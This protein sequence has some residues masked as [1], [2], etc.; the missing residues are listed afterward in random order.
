[1]ANITAER[2]ISRYGAK[3][4]VLPEVINLPMSASLKIWKG[5][6]V[7][8]SLASATKGQA[9]K[10]GASLVQQV[11]GVALQTVDNSSG[12]AGALSINVEAGCFWFGN[13]GGGDAIDLQHIGMPA[14]VVDDQTVALT[15]NGGARL[16]GGTIINLD[17]SLGVLVAVGVGVAQAQ[18]SQG[19]IALALD[20]TSAANATLLTFTPQ[21]NGRIKK[22]SM[23]VN[24]AA[25][26]AGAT[27]TITPN[28]AASPLTGG[29]LTP[30]LGSATLGA[31]LAATAITGAN[32]FTAGQAIT[33]VGSSFTAFTAGNG[34]IY[35]HLG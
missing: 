1:M 4:A 7:A 15:D 23:S 28:I 20:L 26:G 11:V 33:L 27:V 3:S 5:G 21:F 19:T 22:I 31:E 9:F 25:T 30:T 14:Y 8:A 29:V 12:S 16:V 2:S 6:L 32:Y 34:T 24:K 35:L 17:S 13:S 10:A 18:L